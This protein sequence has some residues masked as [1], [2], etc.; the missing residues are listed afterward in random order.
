M[1]APGE[2]LDQKYRIVRLIGEGGMGAVF[3]AEAVRLH[4]R[5]AIKA[6][7][8][9]S[10]S[11]GEMAARFQLEAQAAGRIGSR[12]IVEVIDLGHLPSGAHYMVMEFLEGQSLRDRIKR[13]PMSARE[14]H[15][16]A[17][18]LIVGVGA[19]HAAGIIHRDLKPDNVFLVRQP[20]GRDFVKIL[21]FGISKFGGQL[22]SEHREF[23]LTRTGAL[24]G[25]P[26][27]LSPEQASGSKAVDQRTDLYTVGVILYECLTGV[28]PHAADTFNQLLFAIALEPPPPVSHKIPSADPNFVALVERAMAKD[29]KLRFQSADEMGEALHAWARGEPLPARLGATTPSAADGARA[30]VGLGGG[31]PQRHVATV[32]NG[33]ALANRTVE[34]WSKSRRATGSIAD[35][36]LTGRKSKAPWVVAVVAALGLVGTGIALFRSGPSSENPEATSSSSAPQAAPPELPTATAAKTN[37]PEVEPVLNLPASLPVTATGSEASPSA[38]PSSAASGRT[39]ARGTPRSRA[40]VAASAAPAAPIEVAPAAPVAAPAAP[41]PTADSDVSRI[42]GGRPIR[43][44]L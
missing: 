33:E 8:P 44:D 21:D 12:H 41:P 23:S 36:E 7:H 43:N 22:S 25:T 24:M 40:A 29:P 19:A 30:E 26:Y 32:A 6:L 2:V 28:V 34:P 27:Y 31:S 15:P 16:I 10:A 14:I 38:V 1:L 9:S 18:Q 13:G 4:R 3:E 37:V 42:R 39:P 20:D 11:E 35:V 5:V 17:E